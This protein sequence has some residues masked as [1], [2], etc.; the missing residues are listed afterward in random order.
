MLQEGI[1]NVSGRHTGEAKDK[2]CDGNCDCVVPCANCSGRHFVAVSDIDDNDAE[3]VAL[4][5]TLCG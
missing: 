4:L 3:G 2:E 5:T 1:A